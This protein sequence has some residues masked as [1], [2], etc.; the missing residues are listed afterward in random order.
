MSRLSWMV[1]ALVTL[2]MASFCDRAGAQQFPMVVSPGVHAFQFVGSCQLT[3][4]A[5]ATGL[6]SCV[7]TKPDGTTV[8]GI[9]AAVINGIVTP[10]V[11]VQIGVEG[12][13]IRYVSGGTNPT[14]SYGQPVAAGTPYQYSGPL[15]TVKFLGAGATVN[16]EFFVR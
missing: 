16:I 13:A 12:A 10:A 2:V 3:S 8:S 1:A 9:P 5:V 14:A 15:D 11:L 7:T 6:S 4:L